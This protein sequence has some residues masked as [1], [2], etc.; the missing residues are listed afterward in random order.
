MAACYA[1]YSRK[2]DE[3]DEVFEPRP[4]LH[5][6]DGE[7][8]EE[9]R[10]HQRSP[11]EP[12]PL[13]A[14]PM[15]NPGLPEHGLH[16]SH[17]GQSTLY[18]TCRHSGLG[19]GV[20][21]RDCF[22]AP[23]IKSK[24]DVQADELEAMRYRSQFENAF[25]AQDIYSRTASKGLPVGAL[26]AGR[27]MEPQDDCMIRDGKKCRACQVEDLCYHPQY[28]DGNEIA[29]NSCLQ[30]PPGASKREHWM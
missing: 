16:G 13:L 17:D 14:V 27:T 15:C 9:R 18:G 10:V 22:P 24:A 25:K 12:L 21:G 1:C 30:R 6:T 5:A 11:L 29:V 8:M 2:E 3:E 19:S 4:D 26:G 28:D 7:L 23:P 20:L